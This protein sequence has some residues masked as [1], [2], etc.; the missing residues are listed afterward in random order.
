V[1]RSRGDLAGAAVAGGGVHPQ[2]RRAAT[3]LAAGRI[4]EEKLAALLAGTLPPLIDGEEGR[5]WTGEHDVID[6]GLLEQALAGVPA[7][8]AAQVREACA[9]AAAV[10]DRRHPLPPAGRRLLAR[11]GARP[12]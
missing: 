4:D 5:A 8:Q 11:P 9:V 10:R 6:D 12:S 1:R 3:A 7:V 2:A